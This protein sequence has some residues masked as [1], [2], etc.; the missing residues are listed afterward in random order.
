[1][2]NKDLFQMRVGDAALL[3]NSRM[4]ERK[5]EAMIYEKL[6][7][8]YHDSDLESAIAS[9][10][11]ESDK[12]TYITL[13]RCLDKS[14]AIRRE[15]EDRERK[16]TEEAEAKNFWRQNYEHIKKG[17]C[18]RRCRECKATYCDTIAFYTLSAIKEILDGKR[19]SEDV[20]SELSKKFIGAGFEKNLTP[21]F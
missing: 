20:S 13:R 14:A 6:K 12:L 15:A 8:N 16:Q 21:P 18:N 5:V 11:E 3:L 7:H 17:E 9:L 19:K 2:I 10:L 1:M 4:L